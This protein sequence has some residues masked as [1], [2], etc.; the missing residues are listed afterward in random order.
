VEHLIHGGARRSPPGRGCK[1]EPSK[2]PSA[3]RQTFHDGVQVDGL[4]A[5]AEGVV[6]IQM[7]VTA[8]NGDLRTLRNTNWVVTGLQGAKIHGQEHPGQF[9]S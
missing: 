8:P 3:Q 5:A 7:G 1:P 6:A 9:S 4:S 2:I